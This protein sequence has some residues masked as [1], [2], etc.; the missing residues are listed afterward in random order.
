MI[1]RDKNE[2]LSGP[3]LKYYRN[4][5]IL[6]DEKGQALV[7]YSLLLAV[8]SAISSSVAFFMDNS[9]IIIIAVV[10]V[11]VFLLFWK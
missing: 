4:N 2:K 5:T 9:L 8:S 11:L 7:E 10:A 3:F 1:Y 6:H